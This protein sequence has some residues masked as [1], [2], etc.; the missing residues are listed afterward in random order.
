VTI[1][2]RTWIWGLAGIGVLGVATE[3]RPDILAGSDGR[4]NTCLKST[5]RSLES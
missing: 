5:R 2:H 1:L 3:V 4:R